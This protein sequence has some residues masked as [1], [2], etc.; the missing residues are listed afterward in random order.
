MSGVANDLP[1]YNRDPNYENQESY[2]EL[3]SLV[4]T[5]W[6]SSN[7]FFQPTLTDVQVN[8]LMG[9]SPPLPDGVP[10]LPNGT[11]WLNSTVNKMQF[12]DSTGIVQTITS[13]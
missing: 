2:Q 9:I 13:T 10:P 8:Q 12:V 1:Q 7:G 11:H 6:F 4:L 3:L 5:A